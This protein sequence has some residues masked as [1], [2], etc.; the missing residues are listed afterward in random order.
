MVPTGMVNRLAVIVGSHRRR[1]HRNPQQLYHPLLDTRRSCPGGLPR[2]TRG[3]GGSAWV[4]GTKTHPQGHVP[5]ADNSTENTTH[6]TGTESRDCG[7]VVQA[8]LRRMSQR[9]TK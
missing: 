3:Y 6:R 8:E 5:N 4:G 7:P 2:T 9:I 1:R